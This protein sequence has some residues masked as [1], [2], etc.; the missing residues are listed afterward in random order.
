MPDSPQIIDLQALH[1]LIEHLPQ[2]DDLTLIVLKGHLLVEERLLDLVGLRLRANDNALKDA[3]LRFAQLI[4][5]ARVASG[6]DQYPGLWR[7]LERLNSLRNDL[8]H[9]L[10]PRQVEGLAKA[11]IDDVGDIAGIRRSD[12][13]STRLRGAVAFLYGALTRFKDPK[14]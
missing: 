12:P 5:L 13:I 6:R 4:P 11:I 2:S 1:R 8:A 9:H 10:E 7:A 14:P 3:R